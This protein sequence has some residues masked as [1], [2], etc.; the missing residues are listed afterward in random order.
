MFLTSYSMKSLLLAASLLA[1]SA[2]GAPAEI[3]SARQEDSQRLVFAH[4]MVGITDG[5]T[6]DKWA[7]D[8]AEA[9]A[10]GIDGFALN[11]G[12]QDTYNDVQLPLAYAA[13]EAA[14]DFKLFI[15][16]DQAASTWSVD[17][18]VDRVEQFRDSPAQFKIGG[19]PVVSTFEG[20]DW[21]L[22]NWATVRDRTG[23]IHFIPDWSSLGPQGIA[24][25]LDAIDGACK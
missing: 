1:S 18:V 13:A 20:T 7:A 12:G 10:A 19:I 24:G 17:Q 2:V 16:F 14:N 25:R 3:K 4:Y 6:A 21:G 22:D 9:K 15:S 8:V 5:Q 11:A 23:G